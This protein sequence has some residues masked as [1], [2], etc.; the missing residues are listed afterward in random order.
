MQNN[1]YTLVEDIYHLVKQQGW[2]N[3][4]VAAGFAANLA[5]ELAH[6]ANTEQKPSLRLSQMGPKCPCALWYSIHH[7]ELAEPLP[8]PA[9]IKYT[10]GHI[11]EHMLIMYAK[12]SGHHVVG[13]QDELEVDGIR[14]HR[15]C[16]IDGNIVDVKSCSSMAFRK[17]KDKTLAYSDDFG[18]L[19]QLDG[20]LVGSYDDPLVTNK[21]TAFILAV[22][23][24]LGHIC[25][26]EHRVRRT[27][28][29]GYTIKDRI[30]EYKEIV[31][32]DAPPSCTCETVSEG[33]SG[34]IKLATRAAYSPY[35][36]CCHPGLRTFIYAS[37][38]V[39]LTTVR[40][41]P[42]VTEVDRY[43]KV[44]YN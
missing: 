26:Y 21:E 13:E 20:Y 24:T 12:A 10:Y 37:G 18:Y 9:V 19:D 11:L 38:P 7:P 30:R 36:Y 39:Y 17:F 1:I 44:V 40:R 6:K 28:I 41:K 23:K 14:G 8:P 33:K 43:G 2:F 32:R 16:I 29:G 42:E 31:G 15:D 4:E 3:P 34:N 25:L 5:A 22:D 27:N 35:K